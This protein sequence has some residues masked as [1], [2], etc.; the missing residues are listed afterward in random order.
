MLKKALSLFLAL[1]LCTSGMVVTFASDNANT[2]TGDVDIQNPVYKMTLPVNMNFALDPL[3]IKGQNQIYSGVAS[4]N[5]IN[6]TLLPVKVDFHMQIVAT[7]GVTLVDSVSGIDNTLAPADPTE[8]KLY[9]GVHAAKSVD[10]KKTLSTDGKSTTNVALTKAAKTSDVVSVYEDYEEDVNGYAFQLTGTSTAATTASFLI[11]TGSP[12]TTATAT[13]DD[14]TPNNTSI[15]S[16]RLYAVMTTYNTTWSK[17]DITFEGYYDF[18]GVKQSDYNDAIA[19]TAI[20]PDYDKAP[21]LMKA[22]DSGYTYV[23][24][25]TGTVPFDGAVAGFLNSARTANVT[26]FS[27]DSVKTSTTNLELPFYD[28]GEGVKAVGWGTATFQLATD[29][30]SYNAKTHTLVLKKDNASYSLRSVTAGNKTD[31]YVL[32]NDAA[33]TKITFALNI[34]D[35]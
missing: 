26:P 23:A 32:L 15:A 29:Q 35:S 25:S 18:M 8:K 1:V 34:K 11:N 12:G 27:V 17:K 9:L 3:E 7:N 28:G 20:I 4:I 14:A 21:A 30:W 6:R 33:G 13:A 10:S 22:P 5:V 16:F 2:I 19:D 24:L 31:A